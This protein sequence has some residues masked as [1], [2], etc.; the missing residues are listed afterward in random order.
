MRG[1]R[2]RKRSFHA[3][4]LNDEFAFLPRHFAGGFGTEFTRY[5]AEILA[6]YNAKL[7]AHEA[8][9][10]HSVA[11]FE[12]LAGALMEAQVGLNPDQAEAAPS[13]I[14]RSFAGPGS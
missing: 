5:H 2:G 12:K 1:R 4:D 14:M 13:E 6:E 7:F 3:S 11:D 9:K 10:L 8:G